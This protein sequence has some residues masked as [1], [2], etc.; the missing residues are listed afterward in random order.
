MSQEIGGCQRFE[1]VRDVI[2]QRDLC[3][4][5]DIYTLMIMMAIESGVGLPLQQFDTYFQHLRFLFLLKVYLIYNFLM[6]YLFSA[7]GNNEIYL[8]KVLIK[9]F[10]LIKLIIVLFIIFL[11]FYKIYKKNI[12]SSYLMNFYVYDTKNVNTLHMVDYS[13]VKIS[14]I[15]SFGA[16][17]KLLPWTERWTK[18][19]TYLKN[20]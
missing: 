1:I 20:V 19:H 12:F 13:F 8:W 5:V 4:A 7:L 9:S 6:E 2:L 10:Q 14:Q 18:L 17:R 3:P 15:H 16:M 11:Q